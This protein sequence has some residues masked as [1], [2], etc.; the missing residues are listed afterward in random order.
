MVAAISAESLAMPKITTSR[1]YLTPFSVDDA[2]ELFEIR[3]DREAMAHW[4]WPAD[5]DI[6]QTR[7]IAAS[8]CADMERGSA[9]L[10]TVRL[11]EDPSFA[12]LC[13]LSELDGS[14]S[15]DLGFMFARRHW[16]HGYAREAAEAILNESPRR[17]ITA[18]RARVHEDNARSCRLLGSLGFRQSAVLPEFE[19]RPGVRKTCLVFERD[20]LV[21]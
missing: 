13:D 11:A 21:A 19:I 3:G 12:G 14:G 15:A 5:D 6:E 9:M 7:A 18:A 2:N 17:G 8:M 4:D 16:G 10:W 20:L 1:L